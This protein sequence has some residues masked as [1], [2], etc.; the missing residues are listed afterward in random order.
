MIEDYLRKNS[1]TNANKVAVVCGEESITYGKLYQHAVAR[2]SLLRKEE[3]RAIV[4]RAS[5]TIDFLITYFAIHLADKVSVP[6]ECTT[7]NNR[8]ADIKEF[9]NNSKISYD[10]ADVLFTTGTM[11]KPKGVMITHDA[12]I[13]N[14]ENLIDTQGFTSEHTFIISGPLNH[15]GSLSK[16]W[17]IIMVGGTIIITNGMKD[18]EAFFNALEYPCKKMATFLVPTSLRLLMQFSEERVRSYAKKIDFVETGA[19]PMSQTDMDKLCSILPVSRLYNTYASTETG[20]IATHDYQ[21]DDRI[22]GCLGL[23][24]K[25]S[26]I[27]IGKDGVVTCMGKTLMKGYIGDDN[28]TDSVLHNGVLHTSDLGHF[29][30]KGRLQLDG[31]I[32]DMINVGGYKISPIEIENIAMAYAGIADCICVSRSHTILGTAVKLIYQ[33]KEGEKVSQSSLIAHLKQNLEGYKIPILY[34]QSD[35]IQRTYNGKLNR[36][37]YMK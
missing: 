27:V 16:V 11:G 31:R 29:D 23:P 21:N 30:A 5:Q 6:L 20:I 24:M 13:A 22:A 34:E 9:V 33:V 17:P 2:A 1:I 25:H 7:P 10:V 14:A 26:K 37:K 12:I 15:I 8:F 4:V 35:K 18:L 19:A 36:K 3:T 32:D 28:L